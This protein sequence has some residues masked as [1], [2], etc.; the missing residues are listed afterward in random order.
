MPNS[1]PWIVAITK[2][3]QDKTALTNL[4]QQ[5]FEFFQPTFKT[6]SRVQNKFTEIIK[7][8]FPGYIFIIINLEGTVGIRSIIQ[9]EYLV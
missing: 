5:N 4:E 9:R 7:P 6:M 1:K 3:N 8:V 2:P